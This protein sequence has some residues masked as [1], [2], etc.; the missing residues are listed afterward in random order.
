MVA[1]HTGH[2]IVH[3]YLVSFGEVGA[4]EC[5]EEKYEE[6][7]GERCRVD[8]ND[9]WWANK[10]SDDD[11]LFDV[12][13]DDTRDGAGPST[14]NESTSNTVQDETNL[15]ASQTAASVCSPSAARSG[16]REQ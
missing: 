10:L 5:D 12:D 16:R 9:P 15:A 11:D 4:D 8:L 13:V 7:D 1:S 6:D 3:I 2:F 14:V